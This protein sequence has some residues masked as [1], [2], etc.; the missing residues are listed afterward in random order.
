MRAFASVGVPSRR[1][2]GGSCTEM[3]PKL[4]LLVAVDFSKPSDRAVRTAAAIA[5]K[6][7]ASV[8]IVHARP[9]SDLKAAV[10]EDLGDLARLSRSRMRAGLES[11]YRWLLEKSR[12]RIPEARTRLLVGW[13]SATIAREARRGYDLLVVGSRG[14]GAVSRALLGSTTEELLH[15]SRIPVLVVESPSRSAR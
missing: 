11:H 15:R 5:R 12:R 10:V 13:P 7:G 6:T 1:R 9:S 14:R 2:R 4:R 8:M 3:R